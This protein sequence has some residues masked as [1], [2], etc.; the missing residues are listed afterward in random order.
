VI[1]QSPGEDHPIVAFIRHQCQ[2]GE[3]LLVVRGSPTAEAFSAA[4]S[5]AER[6]G[7]RLVSADEDRVSCPACGTVYEFAAD[8]VMGV[9]D[10]LGAAE[11]AAALS[12]LDLD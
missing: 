7:T 4:Q 1:Y 12:A 8:P 11:A 5:V 3:Q 2:C 10:A 9:V 6:L